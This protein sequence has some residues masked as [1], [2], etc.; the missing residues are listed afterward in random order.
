VVALDAELLKLPSSVVAKRRRHPG[1]SIPF[2][3]YDGGRNTSLAD[4]VRANLAKR[5]VYYVGVMEEKD[6]ASGFDV[7]RAGFARRL[8]PKGQGP[9]AYEVLRQNAPRFSA[10]RF[11]DRDYPSTSWESVIARSYGGVAFDLA[12]ALQAGGRP[13][14]LPH[15]IRLYRTAI[16]LVPDL[17]SAYKNLGVALQASGADREEIVAAWSRFLELRPNDPQAGSIRAELNRLKSG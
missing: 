12:Y 3:S 16:R 5:P 2:A 17:A 15:V 9:D 7:V 4:V 11:P 1:V 10:F 8:L 14:D 13:A 6:F